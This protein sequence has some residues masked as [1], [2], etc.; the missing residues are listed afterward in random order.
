MTAEQ[1]D[2]LI[3]HNWRTQVSPGDALWHLGDIGPNWGLLADLADRK[4][5]I[6]AHAA[7]RPAAI[8]TSA[9]FETIAETHRLSSPAG[10]LLLIN[11]PDL[12][13][14][15]EPAA[16]VPGHHHYDPAKPGRHPV[17]VDH[18]AWAPTDLD[19]LVRQIGQR[20]EKQSR[21]QRPPQRSTISVGSDCHSISICAT[22]CSRTL[23]RYTAS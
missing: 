19:A 10:E 15:G 20:G 12:V 3:E 14:P 1:L 6:L 7:V 9:I 22:F 2:A 8:R 21:R 23:A 13:P 17:C 4:H 18:T 5:L 11:N 16:V